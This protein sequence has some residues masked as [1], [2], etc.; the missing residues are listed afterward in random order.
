MIHVGLN[1]GAPT[2]LSDFAPTALRE[3]Q[4]I[5]GWNQW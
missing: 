1:T 5:Y 2:G 3:I 4:G